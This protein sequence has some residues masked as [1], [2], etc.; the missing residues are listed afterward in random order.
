MNEKSLIKNIEN[1]HINIKT[2]DDFLFALKIC[3]KKYGKKSIF[4]CDGSFDK[5]YIVVTQKEPEKWC[6]I[7]ISLP[8]VKNYCMEKKIDF[9]KFNEMIIGKVEMDKRKQMGRFITLK[10]KFVEKIKNLYC[11]S[12]FKKRELLINKLSEIIEQIEI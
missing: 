10:D 2:V 4:P 12:N 8:K 5:G 1:K 3:R 11:S 6:R 9:L 7:R